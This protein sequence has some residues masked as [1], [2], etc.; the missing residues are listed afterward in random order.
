MYIYIYGLGMNK[1]GKGM[2]NSLIA[3]YCGLTHS[4]CAPFTPI[5]LIGAGRRLVKYSALYLGSQKIIK[6]LKL[7]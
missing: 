1:M 6:I 3:V 4:G 5:L 2:G 7:F